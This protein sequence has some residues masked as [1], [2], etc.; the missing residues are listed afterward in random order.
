MKIV[1]D[2][3]ICAGA[4]YGFYCHIKTITF[5]WLQNGVIQPKQA[6]VS[7]GYSFLP[8]EKKDER[9]FRAGEKRAL[10]KGNTEES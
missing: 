3:R 6:S 1:S 9:V 8:G 7:S 5:N 10:S 2:S 4:Y